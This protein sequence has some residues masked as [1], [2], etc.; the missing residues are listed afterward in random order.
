MQI[1][2]CQ[3]SLVTQCH[4]PKLQAPSD[5]HDAAD[6]VND[7][8]NGCTNPRGHFTFYWQDTHWVAPMN[9]QIRLLDAPKTNQATHDKSALLVQLPDYLQTLAVP[10]W[11][12][13]QPSAMRSR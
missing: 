8:V 2:N 13:S 4:L 3:P 5:D 9:A 1:A 6:Y 10:Q 7:Y 11:P 12:P